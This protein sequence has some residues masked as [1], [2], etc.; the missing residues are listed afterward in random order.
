MRPRLLSLVAVL[1]LLLPAAPV[2]AEDKPAGDKA[3]HKTVGVEEFEK[4]SK[5]PNTVI[6]D[7]RTPAE[8]ATGHLKDAV[9][10][11]LNSKEFDQ[12][13]KGLDKDKTYLVHC[14]VGMRSEKACKRL[15][16]FQFPKVYNLEGG[17]K[18]WK[19]AGKPVEK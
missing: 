3:V 1:C 13:V 16:T 12:K 7:V 2:R 11:D 18:A 14:A 8:Y 4:L 9:L 17:I 19:N 5:E 6:L 15:D 10:I